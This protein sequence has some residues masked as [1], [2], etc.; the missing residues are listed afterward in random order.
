MACVTLRRQ[1]YG[2]EHI[3]IAP[4]GVD[5]GLQGEPGPKIGGTVER[6]QCGHAFDYRTL[7]LGALRMKTAAKKKL[8]V[9]TL[10]ERLT[11]I[12]QEIDAF[13][14]AQVS[15]IK[16]SNGASLPLRTIRGTLRPFSSFSPEGRETA[17]RVKPDVQGF[18]FEYDSP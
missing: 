13:V 8:G 17:W 10:D 4:G 9:P 1:P 3:A 16:N 12:L 6:R 5:R 2:N 15:E 14:E 18:S 7:G 11:A